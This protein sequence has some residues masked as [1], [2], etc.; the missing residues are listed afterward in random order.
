MDDN[1]ARP[2]S[3]L[4]VEHSAKSSPISVLDMLSS[5]EELGDYVSSPDISDDDMVVESKSTGT[6]LYLA[7]HAPNPIEEFSLMRPAEI[8]LLPI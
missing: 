1:V 2:D 8:F 3:V 5:E 6:T 7:L 4:E